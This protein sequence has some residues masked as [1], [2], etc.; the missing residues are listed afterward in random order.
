MLKNMKAQAVEKMRGPGGLSVQLLEQK[1]ALAVKKM[2]WGPVGGMAVQAVQRPMKKK[3]LT[4]DPAFWPKHCWQE[5]EWMWAWVERA[6]AGAVGQK[7]PAVGA[8]GWRRPAVGPVVG[9]SPVL[10][11]VTLSVK[12]QGL[13]AAA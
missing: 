4:G 8:V 10:G 5:E 6:L 2:G 7:G 11:A 3:P 1:R 12:V 13:R 9:K